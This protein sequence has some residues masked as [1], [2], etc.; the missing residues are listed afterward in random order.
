MDKMGDT[1]GIP[2]NGIAY[3]GTRDDLQRKLRARD[4]RITDLEAALDVAEAIMTALAMS[5]RLNREL[6]VD[7]A[8]LT[9]ALSQSRSLLGRNAN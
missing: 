3:T 1:A 9:A 6:V 8:R 5:P 4:D 2:P 7:N